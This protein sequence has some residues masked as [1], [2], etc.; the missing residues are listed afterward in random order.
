MDDAEAFDVVKL[1][2]RGTLSGAGLAGTFHTW[3]LGDRERTDQSLGPRA[4]TTLRI[5]NQLWYAD[6]DGDVRALTGVL[7]RRARTQQF[8]DSG[9]FAKSPQ[10]CVL[11]G[12]RSVNGRSAYALE[13]T[14]D[15]GDTETLYLDEATAL[16]D[17]I[18]YE[19]DDG[20]STIDMSDWRS[21][22][23]HR[24][25]FRVVTSDGDHAFDTTELTTSVDLAPSIDPALFAPL[26]PRRIDMAAPETV[27]LSYS[28]GHLFAPVTIHGRNFTF[29]LDTGAQNVLIDSR[30]A[31][32][33]GL[34]AVGAL[35]ASGAT[36]T[37][38]LR[39]AKL[40]E[41]DVGAGRLHDLVATTLDL[42]TS[43][44]G[45]FRVD[46]IL[47]YPFFAAATVRLDP[48]AKTM[49]FGP[50]GSLPPSGERIPLEID[51]ALLEAPVRLDRSLEARFVIDTGNAGD[52]LLYKPFVDKHRGIVPYSETSRHTY[53][54]GGEADSYRS[55]LDE[56]EFGSIGLFNTD[57]DVMLATR[58]A[59][60][61]RFDAGNVGLGVLQNF[62][63]TFDVANAALYLERSSTFND[64]RART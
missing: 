6:S 57:T 9:A 58:G 23:G 61:D 32:E 29:L 36:R 41:L 12:V 51:R 8:I 45:A 37:G 2:T 30:V 43:T 39:V 19:D 10:C 22:D 48:A 47:G 7:A 54:I 60:A 3:L 24:F 16:P 34:K 13:V 59:F 56:I 28:E 11:R 42:G 35:E 49:T 17:R 18:E 14:A 5:G 38:G 1:E 52:L 50:P 25:P 26:V 44:N 33:L 64:G 21:V 31:S 46:G 53:G 62:I 15:G 27:G 55:A 4:D 40:D 63:I 20:E